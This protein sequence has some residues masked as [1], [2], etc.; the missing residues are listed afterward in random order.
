MVSSL[1]RDAEPGPQV[2]AVSGLHWE[3]G[4]PGCRSDLNVNFSK[5]VSLPSLFGCPIPGLSFPVVLTR[6]SFWILLLKMYLDFLSSN[7]SIPSKEETIYARI[8]E[9]NSGLCHQRL[10]WPCI[11]SLA[12]TSATIHIH[13]PP[14]P[15]FQKYHF[16]T[17]RHCLT[18]SV[19]RLGSKDPSVGEHVLGV[20]MCW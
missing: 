3:P 2:T 18:E 20:S 7:N 8:R 12:P 1:F 16:P 13:H 11:S 15:H 5:S 19:L 9:Q 14:L 17:T 6:P 10:S 4:D